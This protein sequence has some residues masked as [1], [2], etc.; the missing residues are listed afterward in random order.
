MCSWPN[1][2]HGFPSVSAATLLLISSMILY[3]FSTGSI[4]N[5]CAIAA[6][7][8][9]YGFCSNLAPSV[10]EKIFSLSFLYLGGCFWI[11][12]PNPTTLFHAKLLTAICIDPPASACDS[13]VCPISACSHSSHDANVNGL[14]VSSISISI[15]FSTSATWYNSEQWNLQNFLIWSMFLWSGLVSGRVWMSI[16]IFTA[17]LQNQLCTKVMWA[18][19]S[20]TLVAMVRNVPTIT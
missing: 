12:P 13:R 15:V 18:S 9:K 20:T 8:S 1:Y 19:A 14:I 2:C 7:S 11:T 5:A 3:N 17:H 10:I 4:F 16:H 6:S